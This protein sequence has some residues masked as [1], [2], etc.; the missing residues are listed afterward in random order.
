MHIVFLTRKFPPQKGGMETFSKQLTDHLPEPKTI[1]AAGKR[2]SDIL[3]VA[4]LLL[5]KAFGLRRTADCYHL[6]DL[7]LAPVGRL[8]K[9]LTHTPVVVTVHGLELTYRGPGSLLAQ[10]VNWSLP[11]I[12]RFVC[13][14]GNTKQLLL[15]RGVEENRI[16]VIPHG[17][18]ATDSVDRSQ[19]RA[20]VC[21]ELLADAASCDSRPLLLGVGRLVKRKGFEWFIRSV[22]PELRELNPLLILTSDGPERS[23]IEQAV[24]D[25]NQQQQV[26]MLGG[27]SAERLLDLYTGSDIF[28]M[29]NTHVEDDVEGFGFVAIEAAAAGLAV[30]ATDIDGIPEAIH[31]DRNGILIKPGDAQEYAKVVRQWMTHAEDRL[32]FAERAR[33]YTLEHFQWDD[34]VAHYMKVYQALTQQR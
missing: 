13:V 8:L 6:G 1:V 34:V 25:T 18:A 9:T 19:A 31:H 30:A 21:R 14:S 22:L 26:M 24:E 28:V 27:V 11:K 33:L 15:E 29:P 4:P 3:W 10:L 32:A 16:S 20:R 12:D 7:V 2:K 17:V 23:A 5:F